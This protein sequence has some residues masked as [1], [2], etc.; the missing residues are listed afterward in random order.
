MD[1]ALRLTIMFI[2]SMVVFLG[3]CGKDSIET[4]LS[5]PMVD[6][7]F[8]S[9]DEK[10]ISLDTLNGEWWIANFMYT[11][12]EAVCPVTTARLVDIQEELA[13]D[14]L[15]PEIIS[16]SIDPSTDTPDVLNDYAEQ[17]G[18]DLDSWNFLTGYEFEIIQKIAKDTFNSVLERGA[19]G[20][21]SHGVD[22]YLINPEG[23]IVKKYNAMN[24]EELK[25]LVNDLQAVL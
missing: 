23:V 15:K 21:H 17:Y 3:A 20:L 9:Q 14:D 12:C 16:F 8:T 10:M 13:E 2:L 6:F 5:E 22:F 25:K 24:E 18:A 7:E 4:N 1:M 19:E 11:N